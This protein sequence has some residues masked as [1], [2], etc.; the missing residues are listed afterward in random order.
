MLALDGQCLVTGL[1]L[2]LG[3]GLLLPL[4]PGSLE[5]GGEFLLLR[6]RHTPTLAAFSTSWCRGSLFRWATAPSDGRTKASTQL[7]D[8]IIHAASLCLQSFE[9]KLK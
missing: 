6:G 7:G 9:S 1:S 4:R 5:T 2:L 3:R 8:L